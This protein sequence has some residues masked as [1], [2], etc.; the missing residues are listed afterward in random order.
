[1]IFQQKGTLLNFPGETQ[2][3]IRWVPANQ[4]A[5]DWPTEAQYQNMLADMR[6]EAQREHFDI[7]KM[8]V[9]LRILG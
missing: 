9:R 2:G 5:R 8:P 6:E 3:R 7:N 1:M 4:M